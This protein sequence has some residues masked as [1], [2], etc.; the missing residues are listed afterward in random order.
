MVSSKLKECNKSRIILICP[1]DSG[2]TFLLPSESCNRG[3]NIANPN[4]SK[5]PINKQ[6]P[7]TIKNFV[8][9]YL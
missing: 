6:N 5:T 1:N 3:R 2:F 7:I 8:P 4:P 9:M